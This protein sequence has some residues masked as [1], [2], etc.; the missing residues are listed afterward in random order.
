MYTNTRYS[1][2]LAG[3][4]PWF[5]PFALEGFS[6]LNRRVF[7]GLILC[8]SSFFSPSLPTTSAV[9]LAMACRQRGRIRCARGGI[10]SRH[11][12]PPPLIKC[13]LTG[14]IPATM[15]CRR[16]TKVC[17]HLDDYLT[18]KRSASCSLNYGAMVLRKNCWR[19][20][21]RQY[22]LVLYCD[23]NSDGRLLEFR[24]GPLRPMWCKLLIP[25]C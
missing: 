19:D 20:P 3:W 4:R 23:P 6:T 10:R 9:R 5:L 17:F 11:L 2:V 15:P 22:F 24:L 12:P 21:A 14:I 13:C 8:S 16:N 7:C 1:E 18:R 25:H